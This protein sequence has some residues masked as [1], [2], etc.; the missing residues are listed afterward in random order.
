MIGVVVLTKVD[1]EVFRHAWHN[2]T[3][4]KELP[5]LSHLLKIPKIYLKLCFKGISM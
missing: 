5:S 3:F 2:I 4:Q 1:F